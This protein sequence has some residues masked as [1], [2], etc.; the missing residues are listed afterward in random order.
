MKIMWKFIVVMYLIALAGSR[1]TSATA[2]LKIW[3]MNNEEKG[4]ML[5][6]QNKLQRG[7]IP[8]SEPSRCHNR[9]NPFAHSYVYS[10]KTYV[11]CP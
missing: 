10:S 7:P 11:A 3:R 4:R 5:A 6:L 1:G 9:L 8:P 2:R